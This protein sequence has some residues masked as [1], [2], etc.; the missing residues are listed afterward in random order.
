MT[1][2]TGDASSW[3]PAG[4]CSAHRGVQADGDPL[5]KLQPEARVAAPIVLETLVAVLGW[6]ASHRNNCWSVPD[7]CLDA[8][9]EGVDA[10]IFM[11]VLLNDEDHSFEVRRP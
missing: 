11:V 1:M 10:N 6:V 3:S 9:R 7:D 8:R 4:N 5:L 2:F